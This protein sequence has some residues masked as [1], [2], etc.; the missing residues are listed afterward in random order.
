MCIRD[1]CWQQAQSPTGWQASWHSRRQSRKLAVWHLPLTSDSFLRWERDVYKRQSLNRA[2]VFVYKQKGNLIMSDITLPHPNAVNGHTAVICSTSIRHILAGRKS[3]LLQIDTLIRQLTEI[4]ALTENIG[5]KAAPDWA[6][7]QN[8]VSY[9][10]L[11]VYKR[12]R[13]FFPSME[14]FSHPYYLNDKPD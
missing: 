10:H 11:D 3:T 8:S 13:L 9:T 6:M 14:K 7:K 12:Q 2:G 4:S 1:R 5:G